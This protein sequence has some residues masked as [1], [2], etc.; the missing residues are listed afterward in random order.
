MSVTVCHHHPSLS[1]QKLQSVKQKHNKI[2]EK[3]IST[4]MK[5]LQQFVVNLCKS[6]LI[7]MERYILVTLLSVWITSTYQPL[8]HWGC[9]SLWYRLSNH[10]T[11]HFPAKSHVQQRENNALTDHAF[12][13][14]FSL[15]LTIRFNTFCNNVLRKNKTY[16]DTIRW[17]S[18]L[19]NL[20]VHLNVLV[21]NIQRYYGWEEK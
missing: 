10:Q 11:I 12:F 4:I 14:P 20:N 3:C 8:L 19:Y 1:R 13:F 5:Y 2:I 21:N 16:I 17:P 9:W 18:N 15:Q 7:A 6:S